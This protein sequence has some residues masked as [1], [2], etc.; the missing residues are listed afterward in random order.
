MS[1]GAGAN[2]FTSPIDHM[3]LNDIENLILFLSPTVW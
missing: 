2:G 1:A 3:V